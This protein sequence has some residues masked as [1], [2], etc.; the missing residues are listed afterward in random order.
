M[1]TLKASGDALRQLGATGQGLRAV[2]DI[3]SEVESNMQHAAEIASVLSSG[4]VTGMVNSMSI[5]GAVVDE[6]D[7]MRELQSLED[8]DGNF[9]DVA[10]PAGTCAAASALSGSS[11]IRSILAMPT[12]SEQCEPPELQASMYHNTTSRPQQQQQIMM[13]A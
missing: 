4:S 7:L 1:E 10:M 11:T 3:V 6:D 2:E 5:N 12:I 13:P 9:E 8:M